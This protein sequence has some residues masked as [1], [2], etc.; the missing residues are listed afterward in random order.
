MSLSPPQSLGV[1]MK[2]KRLGATTFLPPSAIRSAQKNQPDRDNLRRF[3]LRLEYRHQVQP[4]HPARHDKF[5]ATPMRPDN[6]RY[7]RRQQIS[8]L[9]L[10][11]FSSPQS[12]YLLRFIS[13]LPMPCASYQ[14][15][16]ASRI[17][18]LRKRTLATPF[19]FR[20]LPL[21]YILRNLVMSRI[22]LPTAIALIS[23]ISLMISKFMNAFNQLVR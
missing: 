17:L 4:H 11:V 23:V 20:H 7:L 1:A 10:S 12:K 19:S 2:F 5:Y 3:H 8:S 13:R 22:L 21:P 6:L 14:C 9:F 16:S 15:N 18:P